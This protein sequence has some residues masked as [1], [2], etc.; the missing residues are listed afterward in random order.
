MQPRQALQQARLPS[1]ARGDDTRQIANHTRHARRLHVNH[2]RGDIIPETM[3]APLH[4]SESLAH[5]IHDPAIEFFEA[6]GN[7]GFAGGGASGG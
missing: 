5:Q 7:L 6:G 1:L 3:A 2:T 4:R